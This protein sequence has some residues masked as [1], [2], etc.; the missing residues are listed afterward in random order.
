MNP[1]LTIIGLQDDDGI[2]TLDITKR[3]EEEEKNMS[4]QEISAFGVFT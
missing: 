1:S 4:L 2:E 3:G